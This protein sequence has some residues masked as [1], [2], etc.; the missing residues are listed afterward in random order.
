MV[1]FAKKKRKTHKYIFTSKTTKK[2]KTKNN[3]KIHKG[4]HDDNDDYMASDES[5]DH[6]TDDWDANSY[7]LG[8]PFFVFFIFLF[9]LLCF[10]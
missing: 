2:T 7:E 1:F 8:Y 10:V 4:T 6:Y 5:D 3:I 9:V